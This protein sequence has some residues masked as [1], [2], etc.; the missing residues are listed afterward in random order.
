MKDLEQAFLVL[1]KYTALKRK[2]MNCKKEFYIVGKAKEVLQEYYLC[3]KCD[4]LINTD[5]ETE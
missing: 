2:C 1:Q 3:Y 5:N 4:N